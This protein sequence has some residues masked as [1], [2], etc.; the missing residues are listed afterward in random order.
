MTLRS[1]LSNPVPLGSCG[2]AARPERAHRALAMVRSIAKHLQRTGSDTSPIP[3]AKG[4]YVW[5]FSKECFLAPFAWLVVMSAVQAQ[6]TTAVGAGDPKSATSRESIRLSE[7]GQPALMLQVQRPASSAATA[8]AAGDAIY[9]HGATFGADLSIFYRFDGR[10]WADEINAIGLSVWGF[11]FAGYGKSDPYPAG[12]D[13]P[14]GRMDDVIAQLRRVVAAVRARNGDRP[15]A[16]VAHSWGA[17]VAARYA[18]MYPEDVKALVLFAPIVTRT[19]APR[20]G[21][22]AAQPSYYPLTL[23]AQYRRFIEDVPRGQPQ[24]LSEAHF[25]AW[26]AAYLA[27]DHRSGERVPPSVMT[28]YGPV[29]DI[30]ALWSGQSLYDPSLITAPTIVVHGE[31]DSLCTDA[32]A[33]RLLA[34]LG[35]R[36]KAGVRIEHATHLMHL[37]SQRAVLYNRV[38]T[39]LART[40]K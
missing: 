22:A 7:P 15:V 26:G 34:G 32:D 11:D 31:W 40:M 2:A 21:P 24:V 29:A 1:L 25:Q 33:S 27:T 14:A 3:I 36:D 16:L 8:L 12:G 35:A 4:L 13:R 20:P 38:N 6:P 39:F 9:V 30:V 37:E 28:P 17:S 5:S 18:G 23:W 10:S 19:P